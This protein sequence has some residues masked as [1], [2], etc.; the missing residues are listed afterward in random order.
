MV[1]AGDDMVVRGGGAGDFAYEG[2]MKWPRCPVDRVLHDG[3]DVKLGGTALTAHLT[4]GHTK[5]CT[6]WTLAVEENGTKCRV[7]IIGATTAP[8]GFRLVHNR[9]YPAIAED[10]KRTFDLLAALPC[11]IYLGSHTSYYGMKEKYR[12]SL[13]EGFRAFADPEGYREFLERTRAA[14][15]RELENQ[16]RR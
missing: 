7:V 12:R 8:A 13:A 10:Y 15:L 14:F 2:K 4:P 9:K 6:T 16:R 3:D 11:D 5:G 1:M